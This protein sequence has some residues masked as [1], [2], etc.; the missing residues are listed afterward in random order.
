MNAAHFRIPQIVLGAILATGLSSVVMA[1]DVAV[2]GITVG[3]LGNP[4]FVAAAKGIEARAKKITP[5]AKVIAVSSDFDLGKQ[6]TQV[7][8]FIGAGAQ[9][10]MINAADPVAIAPGF[11]RANNAGFVVGAFDGYA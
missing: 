2:V 8:N 6:F 7:D 5:N 3:S 11:F 10:L 9:I 1:T 4:Y